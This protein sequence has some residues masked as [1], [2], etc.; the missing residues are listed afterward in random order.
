M[1]RVVVCLDGMDPEYLDAVETP[2][3]DAIAGAGTS[4]EC[5]C[6]VPSLTNVNNVSIVTASF[7]ETHGITGNTFFDRETGE[8]VY[9]EGPEFLRTG[10]RLERAAEDGESVVALVAKKKLRR[11]VGRG[12]DLAAAAEEPPEWLEEAVGPAPDI[13]S[14]EASPWLMDAAVHVLDERD[15]DLLYVSTT[16]VVPHKHAPD[17]PVAREWVET[18]DDGL[19]AIHE[20]S[21]A[22]V[23]TADHGMNHK[24]RCVDL[25][26]ILKAEGVDAEVVRLIRDRHTY[27]HQNLGGAAYVYLTDDREA[28]LT[29]LEDVEGVEAVLDPTE[30]GERFHLPAD[31]IG[32]AL[33]LGTPESV[34]GPIEADGETHADV[35][36]R[37]HGSHHEQAVPYAS[38]VDV[39]MENN[40]DAFD[41]VASGD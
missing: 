28:D 35:D 31:R 18:M 30:A 11:M 5:D 15:P 14:G 3:W 16:D 38:T 20:R 2:G 1:T 23:A 24:S 36:L 21:D 12:C 37:S 22:V 32:D 10:T 29:A 19:A 39:G 34:F 27:H 9:M 8:R 33:V 25:A 40:L 6:V 26:T 17:D 7:P 4:G 41:V 13:Y